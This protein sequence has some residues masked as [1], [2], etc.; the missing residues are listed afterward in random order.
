MSDSLNIAVIGAGKMGKHHIRI[1]SS[2]PGAEVSHVCDLDKKA[3]KE[4][5]K[6]YGCE[7]ETDYKKL[8]GEVDAVVI[9]T[10]SVTHYKIGSFFLENKIPCLIEKPLAV[11]DKECKTLVDLAKKNKTVLLVGHVER[12]SPAYM[13]MTEI[14]KETKDEVLSVSTSRVSYLSGR[15][16]D[17]DVVSDLMVH[18]LDL[19]LA[20]VGKKVKSVSAKCV[21]KKKLQDDYC[22]ALVEF[23]DGVVA[24]LIASRVSQD[25]ER[26]MKVV[27]KRGVFKVN[28]SE[29]RLEFSHA[30]EGNLADDYNS[31]ISRESLKVRRG[32]QLTAEIV[33]FVACVRGDEKP[34]VSG[35]DGYAAMKLAWRIRGQ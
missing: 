10:T 33:H 4:I 16:S 27:T 14:I 2:M 18:D 28:F 21:S 30:P 23:N 32:D 12:F 13:R 34:I 29:Q 31:Y 1:L 8:L 6:S 20:L 22:N 19:V 9:S 5:A 26:V 3:V 25:V 17:V 35:E 15:I 24:N 11:N 7:W